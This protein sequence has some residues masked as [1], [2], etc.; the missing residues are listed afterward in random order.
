MII[1]ALQQLK[2]VSA[3][4]EDGLIKY[5][6]SQVTNWVETTIFTFHENSLKKVTNEIFWIISFNVN[7]LIFNQPW[8]D[9]IR[10]PEDDNKQDK[11]Y[12]GQLRQDA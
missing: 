12:L 9:S 7:S 3:A 5:V 11:W 4:D 6:R 10:K 2:C 1:Q 8:E